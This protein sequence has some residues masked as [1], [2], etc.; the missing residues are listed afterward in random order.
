MR[1][2]SRWLTR[3]PALA[4]YRCFSAQTQKQKAIPTIKEFIKTQSG[5]QVRKWEEGNQAEDTNLS[6]L[7]VEREANKLKSRSYFIETHGC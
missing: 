3:N 5:E 1:I 7:S 4:N 6:Y 2:T